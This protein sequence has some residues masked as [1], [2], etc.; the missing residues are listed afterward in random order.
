MTIGGAAP[1]I[2]R[3]PGSG[4]FQARPAPQRPAQSMTMFMVRWGQFI[5]FAKRI[6]R[7]SRR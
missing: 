1:P 4:D 7:L 6:R 2:F 5:D 3:Q